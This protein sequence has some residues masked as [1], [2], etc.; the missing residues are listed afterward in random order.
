M[1]FDVDGE[2]G[3]PVGGGGG[4]EVGDGRETGPALLWKYVLAKH[5]LFLSFLLPI[6]GI[7][8]MTVFG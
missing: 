2:T 4:V 7:V 5:S 6:L 3:V 1:R 8:L